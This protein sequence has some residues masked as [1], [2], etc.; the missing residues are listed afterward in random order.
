MQRITADSPSGTVVWH[1]G[2]A[3]PTGTGAAFEGYYC[4]KPPFPDGLNR[5]GNAGCSGTTQQGLAPPK[6][7]YDGALGGY[8]L[9]GH[10]C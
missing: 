10:R 3:V 2:D 6:R 4:C 5:G 7:Y 9:N 1:T 8:F